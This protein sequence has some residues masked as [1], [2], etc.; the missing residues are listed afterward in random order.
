MATPPLG[1]AAAPVANEREELWIEERH[2]LVRWALKI[3]GDVVEN[4][5]P[6]TDFAAVDVCDLKASVVT[7]AVEKG[8][9]IEL[10]KLRAKS[11]DKLRRRSHQTAPVLDSSTPQSQAA[12]TPPRSPAGAPVQHVRTAS[13][14]SEATVKHILP[15]PANTPDDSFISTGNGRSRR[16]SGATAV[17]SRSPEREACGEGLHFSPVLLRMPLESD[18]RP[19]RPGRGCVEVLRDE[20]LPDLSYRATQVKLTAYQYALLATDLRPRVLLDIESALQLPSAVSRGIAR[21]LSLPSPEL[22]QYVVVHRGRGEPP[23]A[24]RRAKRDALWQLECLTQSFERTA[25]ALE[26]FGGAAEALHDWRVRTVLLLLSLLEDRP[27]V[28]PVDLVALAQ[29]ALVFLQKAGCAG[30]GDVLPHWRCIAD[31]FKAALGTAP[32]FPAGLALELY[33][34]LVH[35]AVAT[36]DDAEP[37]ADDELFATLEPLRDLWALTSSAHHLLSTACEAVAIA[38]PGVRNPRTAEALAEALYALPPPDANHE[39]EWSAVVAS[40]LGRLYKEYLVPGITLNAATL[41]PVVTAAREAAAKCASTVFQRS[42]MF[43]LDGINDRVMQCR[44][45]PLA[46]PGV[47]STRTFTP[48]SGMGFDCALTLCAHAVWYSVTVGWRKVLADAAGRCDVSIDETHLAGHGALPV[49]VGLAVCLLKDLEKEC[50]R[51]AALIA[52]AG[53]GAAAV[54]E[55][56]IGCHIHLVVGLVLGTCHS[57]SNSNSLSTTDA[58]RPVSLP[59][60][61]TRSFLAAFRQWLCVVAPDGISA[62]SPTLAPPLRRLSEHLVASSM[63][64]VR[65]KQNDITHYVTASADHITW[66]VPDDDSW[67]LPEVR[68]V[69]TCLND[70]AA[71]LATDLFFADSHATAVSLVKGIAGNVQAFADTVAQGC[72]FDVGD[73]QT[74]TAEAILEYSAQRGVQESILALNTLTLA[75]EEYDKLSDSLQD[76]WTGIAQVFGGPIELPTNLDVVL[77]LIDKM[78][79]DVLWYLAMLLAHT[80]H[81]LFWR[82][83]LYTIDMKHYKKYKHDAKYLKKNGPASHLQYEVSLPP[84][85]ERL[86]GA[87]R[88]TLPRILGG[89]QVRLVLVERMLHIA[90]LLLRWVVLGE[91][92]QGERIG[93]Y[94]HEKHSLQLTNDVQALDEFFNAGGTGLAMPTIKRY[95]GQLKLIVQLVMARTTE[96]LLAGGDLS[97]PYTSLPEVDDV[98]PYSQEVVRQ[99]F[100]HRKDQ[101]AKK[102]VK[103]FCK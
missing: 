9:L 76:V 37:L 78:R 99:I 57:S 27:D 53:D 96:E 32:A 86:D 66:A 13:T 3:H 5:V 73:P 81:G 65:N 19:V 101:T 52:A 89:E 71:V 47:P 29:D 60:A 1:V 15:S 84:Y 8:K 22:T 100:K 26:C 75:M 48:T 41:A 46:S 23:V 42:M 28:S 12:P 56:V 98:K 69:F 72:R 49:D 103:R 102:F 87:M 40:L 4:G 61:D 68:D 30:P 11:A 17:R 95:T 16:D 20:L 45:F 39:A 90:A 6:V 50:K 83:D 24:L 35:L 58:Q 54:Q 44:A 55:V 79:E 21:A 91:S 31:A 82:E 80:T 88:E 38:A 36:R 70:N 94:F 64:Y 7:R 92:S 25:E 77:G 33:R 74:L 18:V 43:V 93:R 85:L 62:A 51:Y 97:L 10:E 34:S 67:V 2:T 63:T 59:C 14:T